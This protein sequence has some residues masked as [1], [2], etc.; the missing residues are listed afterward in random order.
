MTR[1]KSPTRRSRSRS[2]SPL[3]GMA[4]LVVL[5]PAVMAGYGIVSGN[6]ASAST[7]R[8]GNKVDFVLNDL[9]GKPVHLSDYRGHPILV[10]LWASWCPPC[11]LEMPYLIKYYHDH[12]DEG[13]VFL[14]VNSTDSFGPALQ[15]AQQQEMDFPVVFDPEGKVM[16]LFGTQGLPSSYLF[17]KDGN[18][19]YS[20]V[21]MISPN[22]LNT[23]VQPLLTK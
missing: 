1:R 20:N 13:F 21:G 5:L 3:L 14:A 7:S 12:K 17:D 19:V 22:D 9:A 15:F 6:N 23:R 10:N 11:R 18:L 2:I 8:N 4:L 16:Q